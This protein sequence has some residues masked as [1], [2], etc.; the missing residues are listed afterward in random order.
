MTERSIAHGSFSVERRF[1]APPSRVYAAFADP[2]QK[3]RWFGEG[4][5]EGAVFDF[6]EGGHEYNSGRMDE[7]TTYIF[8]C[9]YHDIV[10]DTRLVYAYEMH[11]NG[12]RIS[13]SLAS[14]EFRPDGDGTHL[15]ITEHG[16]F[17]DGLDTLEQRRAGTEEL[18]N[19][20][21]GHLEKAAG[22]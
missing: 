1:P 8:D 21:G 17:L 19:Q 4:E 16:M 11:I 13:V 3:K 12:R 6:R 9:R 5:A 22:A 10:P 14:V 7:E 20:L 15:V 2:A 18:M